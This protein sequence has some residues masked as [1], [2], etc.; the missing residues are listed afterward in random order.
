M[1]KGKTTLIQ[2]DP[3]KGTAPNNY[4]PI[5]CL[6]MMWKILTA[7]IR[8]D[9]YYSLTSRGLFPDEQKGCRK[10]SRGTTELL[11]I[12]Q[13]ILSESR[14]RRKNL[15]MAW[16]DYK[17]AHDMVPQS[18]II[19][20]LKTYKIS[21]EVI[22]FIEKNMKNWRIELTAGGKSLAETKTQIAIFQG[23]ALS[24]LLFIIATML[25]NHIP[26]KCTAGYKLSRS[27]EK[28][29][30]LMYM[31]DIKLFAK[32]EKELETLI[33]SARIFSQDIGMEFG[34][35][36]CAL[37]VMK[38]GKR[39]KTDGIELPNQDKIRTF[40]ENEAYKYLGIMEADT[41]KQVEMKDKIQKEYLRRTWKLLETKLSSRNLIKGI[42]TWAVPLVRYSVPFL[43]WTRDE[44][45]QIDQRTRKL[46]IMHKA[47]HLRDDV[48]RL[49]VPRKEGGRGLASIEDSIDTSIQR[50]ED[51][52]KNTNEDWL[53]PS[54]TIR[55]TR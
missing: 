49:Y 51:Y 38:S 23:D 6:P 50:L 45:R 14:N 21:H 30:H 52:I 26:R 4:T 37:L 19:N 39:H 7:Q 20:C 42:N 1:T 47:L 29:N 17:K 43:K 12:D 48:N 53:W 40:V 13:H 28:I 55:T 32:N 3:S 44:L 36:K 25:L 15:A 10:G 16:I 33:H 22:N 24:P 5:I 2:K 9:I 41:I 46:M 34:I 18:W 8:E 11:Y 54:E 31:D 35:E 27:Q